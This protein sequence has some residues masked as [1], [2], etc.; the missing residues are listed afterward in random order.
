MYLIITSILSTASILDR[1]WQRIWDTYDYANS[2]TFSKTTQ[3]GFLGV[4]SVLLIS[5]YR[6][7]GQLVTVCQFLKDFV[8]RHSTNV[9]CPTSFSR[10][11]T[12]LYIC[13]SITL[14]HS[15]LNKKITWNSRICKHTRQE[16]C[17][18]FLSFQSCWHSSSSI[19]VIFY[20]I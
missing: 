4:F 10:F 5:A 9:K 8:H 18:F 17:I 1:K 13:L 2:P 11:P 14:Q 7:W 20:L 19:V 12:S 15:Q 6:R 3:S 16:W